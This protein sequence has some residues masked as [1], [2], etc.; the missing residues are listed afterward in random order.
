M[1]LDLIRESV[2]INEVVCEDSIQTVVE[3][4]IIVPDVKPDIGRILLLDGDVSVN[5]SEVMQDKIAATGTIRYKILYVCDDESQNI[6]SINTSANFSCDLRAENARQ[7]MR[8][9]VKCEIEHMEYNILNGRKINVRSIV[10]VNGGAIEEIEKDVIS[11]LKG[12]EDIQLLKDNLDV[13]CYVGYNKIDFNVSE[14][15]EVPAGKP[16]IREI[17]RNDIKI[18][19]KDSKSADNKIIARGELNVT[20]L[21]IGDDEG[22]SFQ[23]MEHEIPFTQFIDMAGVNENSYCGL[24]YEILDYQFE[25]NEDSDGELRIVNGEIRIGLSAAAYE[26]KNIQ[27]LS[28]AYT[29]QFGIELEKE[30]FTVEEILLENKSQIILKDTI[31]INEGPEIAEVFNVLCNPVLTD[32]NVYEDKIVVEGLI[33]NNILYLANNFEQ[34]VYCYKQEVPFKQNLDIKGVNPDMRCDVS[35]DIEHYNYSVVSSNEVEI[36]LAVGVSVKALNQTDV[37]LVVNVQ[38]YP[39][40]NTNRSAQPSLTLYY[41]QQG[42]TL[43]KIAKRYLTTIEEIKRIN[44]ISEKDLAVP[45]QQILIPKKAV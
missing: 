18:T 20:T 25:P 26:K 4:D 37:P 7:G 21:Y 13:N 17:L 24:D 39:Y 29:P 19:G 22:N 28:D 2:K 45:G 38:E 30:P 9:V 5:S 41:S 8:P 6:K 44:N 42:D 31:S 27:T 34:P 14:N 36:R 33:N 10:N 16:A 15:M 3:N 40:D 12:T 11:D 43:W 23:S 1:S 35:L 32:C